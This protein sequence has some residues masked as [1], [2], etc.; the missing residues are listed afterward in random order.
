[1]SFSLKHSVR[2]FPCRRWIFLRCSYPL[3]H[4]TWI[5][6]FSVSQAESSTVHS[7]VAYPIDKRSIFSRF[8]R[9]RHHSDPGN[10]GICR[11]SCLFYEAYY[12]MQTISSRT[13]EVF[14]VVVFHSVYLRMFYFYTSFSSNSYILNWWIFYLHPLL[15]LSHENVRHFTFHRTSNRYGSNVCVAARTKCSMVV[16]MS[17]VHIESKTASNVILFI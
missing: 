15:Y 11:R 4:L 9:V 7:I 17:V 1:M 14:V 6:L 8:C 5:F 3:P 10:H 16:W 13:L 12:G 2:I